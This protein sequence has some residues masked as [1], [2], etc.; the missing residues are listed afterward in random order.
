MKLDLLLA[1]GRVIIPATPEDTRIMGDT[2]PGIPGM[3]PNLLD[4]RELEGWL[5]WS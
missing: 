4:E 5:Q 3:S 2:C 1:P